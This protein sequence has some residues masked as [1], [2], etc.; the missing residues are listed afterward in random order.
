MDIKFHGRR[1]LTRRIRLWLLEPN[2]RAVACYRFSH[3]TSEFYSRHK[4]IGLLPRVASRLWRQRCRT[5]DKIW[6][7]QEANIGPGLYIAWEFGVTVGPSVIGANC[8]IFQ[9]VTVGRQ[10]VG[11][12]DG[13]PRIGDNVYIGP[14]STITGPITIGNNVTI[15]AGTVLSKSVPDRCLVAGN[16]GRVI[17]QD[18]DNGPLIMYPVSLNGDRHGHDA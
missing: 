4:I 14:G 3:A 17:Q 16:P 1:L 15:S 5:R 10:L 12:G 13:V 2:F 8:M 11:D 9:N 6:I 7:Q 18:Y